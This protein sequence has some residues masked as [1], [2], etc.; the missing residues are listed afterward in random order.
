MTC[1]GWPSPRGTRRPRRRWRSRPD[2]RP[3]AR[4]QGP[5]AAWS[6]YAAG[7]AYLSRLAAGESPAASWLASPTHRPVAGLAGCPGRGRRRRPCRRAG[8]RPRGPGPPRRRARGCRPH[9]GAGP[10]PPRPAHGRPGATGAL[11][12][13]AQGAAWARVRGRGHPGGRV[14]AR[15]RAGPRGVVG[16]RRRP[17]GR[18]RVALPPRPRRAADA[19]RGR[20]GGGPVRR[21]HAGPWPCSG[22]STPASC[23]PSPAAALRG[24][25]PRV[26]VAG[27]GVEV[28]RDAA[29]ASAHL[30]S[31]AWRTAK[32]A[33]ESGPVLVQVPR[34]G[35]VPSLS[36]QTCR[37][38]VRCT[39][40]GGPVALGSRRP[41][42]PAA[43]A[44]A[45]SGGS[46][47]GT[48]EAASCGRP[49]SAPA[50]P[51]RSWA[52]PSPACRCTPRARVPCSTG[53][54]PRRPWSSRR[55]APNPWPTAGMPRACCSTPGPAS[56]GPPWTRGRRRCVA[57]WPPAP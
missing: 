31:I 45:G 44:A 39:H 12:R 54:R 15:A 6:R 26:Q 28:E 53:W 30:P 32:A 16:R 35:Y 3:A 1:S 33:L 20:G 21:V 11:H 37:T 36:C 2:A 57:G 22:S 38:A 9:R 14:R 24:A 7:P 27:E 29:A 43:G 25:V 17:A 47:A 23:G 4:G 48:A 18:A 8:Q 42:R 13:V 41:S 50:G 10:R 49:W 56:T 19:G 46:S 55:R 52:G 40:C 34:R 51:P 5:G